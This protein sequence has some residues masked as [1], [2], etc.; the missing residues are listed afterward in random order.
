MSN[1][2]KLG[3]PKGSL[4]NSTI[5]LFAKAGFKISV[6]SR[7]YFPVCD[8][9]EIECMLIRA[10]EMA[11][12]VENGILD[13]GLTGKDW[14]AENNADVK[15]ICELVYAK[16]SSRP[17]RWVLA[18]PNNSNINSVKDL[19]GKKIATEAVEMTRNY[20]KK[21][22]VTAEVEF[23]WG[24]TEVKPP[25][26]VDAIVEVTETGS[27]L[28]ANNL[29]IIDTVMEST[30]RLIMNKE[31]FND[32]WKKNKTDRIAMLLIGAMAAENKVGI[33]FNLRADKLDEVLKKVPALES[34]TVS[35]LYEK[36]WVA[37]TTIIDENVVR[38]LIPELKI[39]GAVGIVEYPLNKVIY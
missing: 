30:P 2:L 6:Q 26:L 23:S 16:Q 31:A 35:H 38:N 28:R 10:Q 34:P 20:L 32:K 9:S 8:D 24:A 12:Y 29:K 27:S 4:Q 36:G 13:I 11:R 14:I 17:V 25:N 15:E 21:H 7:S 18:A 19:Q 37:V 39:S 1:I 5:S 3:L 22:N 33:M